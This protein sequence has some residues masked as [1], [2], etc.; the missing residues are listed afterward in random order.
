[1]SRLTA[2]QYQF[3]CRG[4][5][6]GRVQHLRGNSHLEAW[7]VRRHLIRIFGFGGFDITTKSTTLV[8]Q[9]EHPAID[10][11]G[12]PVPGGKSRWTVVYT[13]E[14]RLTIKHP[15]GTIL[16]VLEDGAAGD[17]QN[18]P[19][20]GDAHDQALK[21]AL[22]QGLKRC[23]VNL[24]DQFGLSLYNDGSADPVVLR[25]LVTPDGDSPTTAPPQDPPVKPEPK[26]EN[27][28]PTSGAPVEGGPALAGPEQ[29]LASPEQRAELFGLLKQADLADPEAAL[30]YINSVIKPASVEGTKELTIA[31]AVQVVER[32][33]S[34]IAQQTPPATTEPEPAAAPRMVTDAQHRNMHAIWRELGFDGD[35]NR[36][37]RLTVMTKVLGR[38]VETSKS[39][40]EDEAEGVIAALESKRRE[41]RSKGAAAQPAANEGP[42]TADQRTALFSLL[43]AA[44]LDQDKVKALAR[45][46]AAIAPA[47]VTTTKALTEF[48]AAQ[49]IG[50]LQAPVGA[51]A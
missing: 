24:G 2:S 28:A 36:G 34:F 29:V 6:N 31:Q 16:T 35:H 15:D 5:D 18:Q 19:S 26:P 49:A 11:K 10:N 42:M 22:S 3:L 4:I 38:P 12:I 39:L 25:S 7:D 43:K 44:G 51:A 17:S 20:L 33:R 1:M 27:P 50:H 32:V 41:L 48:Q 45:I 30:R 47:S 14:I 37:N 46:N 9:I 40:T 8:A 21:T 23:V 13:A